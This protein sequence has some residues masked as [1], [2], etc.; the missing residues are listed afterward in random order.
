ML[1]TSKL[2]IVFYYT[3]CYQLNQQPRSKHVW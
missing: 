2:Q 1:I 3:V